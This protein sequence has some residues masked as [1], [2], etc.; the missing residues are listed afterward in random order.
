MEDMT[1]TEIARLIEGL[2]SAGWEEKKINNSSR[3]KKSKKQIRQLL[4]WLSF[5]CKTN[6]NANVSRLE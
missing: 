6:S 1:M 5:L 4:R 3:K 2:R